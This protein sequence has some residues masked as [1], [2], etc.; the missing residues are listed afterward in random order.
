MLQTL[1]QNWWAIVLRGIAAVL[2][3]LMAF[4]W[5]GITLAAL[6]LLYGAFAFV[7]G[8]LAVLWSLVRRPGGR[9]PWGVFLAG[10]VGIASGVI[11]FLWPALTALALLYLVAGWAIVRGVFEIIAAF[12]LRREIDNEW[13]LAISGGLSVLLGIILAAA[14]EAGALALLWWIGSFAVIVGVLTIFLGLRLRR[15]GSQLARQRA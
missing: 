7:D 10:L 3:G 4:A 11:A 6:V 13:L 1:A 2:F 15:V 8:V 12:H 14:P 5:P 9:F